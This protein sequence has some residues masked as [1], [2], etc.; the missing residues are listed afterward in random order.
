[1]DV[2]NAFCSQYL[3]NANPLYFGWVLVATAGW[4]F[5][6]VFALTSERCSGFGKLFWVLVTA[7]FAWLGLA[8][9][10]I[11]THRPTT[12]KRPRIAG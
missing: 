11:A 6:P 1:M 7:C 12:V 2:F 9:F 5:A 10:L 4:G 8:L 3:N